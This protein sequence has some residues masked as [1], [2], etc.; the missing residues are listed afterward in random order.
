M[1]VL[2]ERLNCVLNNQVNIFLHSYPLQLKSH[3]IVDDHDLE[4]RI[5]ALEKRLVN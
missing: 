4:K 2:Q 5:D 1:D 3:T